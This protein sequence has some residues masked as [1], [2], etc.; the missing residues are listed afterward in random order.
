[1]AVSDESVLGADRLKH[2]EFIQGVITRLGTNSFLVKGW[3]LTVAAA[4]YGFL[5]SR[6]DWPVALAGLAP[7]LAFWALD[8][9][10]LW[11]EMLYRRLYDD[12][13]AP[14][15][16]VELMS[17]STAPYLGTVSWRRAVFS[18]TPLFFYG[19]L[20]LVDALLVAVAAVAGG[21]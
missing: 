9:Y 3:A 5:A 10:Y 14:G 13:R 4:F 7:L 21:A 2:L 6:L 8:G 18:R 11:Q 15:S 17:M 16:T 1:M 19:A 12:V 20:V